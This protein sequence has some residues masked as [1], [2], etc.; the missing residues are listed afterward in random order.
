MRWKVG[1]LEGD[2]VTRRDALRTAAA[3]VTASLLPGAT[4]QPSN[5]PTVRLKQSASRWCYRSISL[6]DLCK[7]GKAMG[8]AGI[9]LLAPEDWPVVRQNGLVCSMGYAA[10][11]ADSLPPRFQSPANHHLQLRS[12]G[13]A[14][15]LRGRAG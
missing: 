14:P 8:L 4:V 7:A 13:R 15:P 6:P 3:A 10:I 2:L 11:R 5:R 1:R 12:P 9:D